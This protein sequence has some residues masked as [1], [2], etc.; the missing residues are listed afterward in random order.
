MKIN[1]NQNVKIKLNGLGFEILKKRHDELNRIIEENGGESL[2][3]F[4]P[5]FDLKG[6]YSMQMWDFMKVF[7]DYMD[8]CCEIPFE[9]D[10]IIEIF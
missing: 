1:L 5:V 2:G 7:G 4:K 9:M 3:T 6:Y 10:L 8:P